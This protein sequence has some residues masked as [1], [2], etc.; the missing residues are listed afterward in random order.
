MLHCFHFRVFSKMPLAVAE[1]TLSSLQDKSKH[2]QLPMADKEVQKKMQSLL[3]SPST[4]SPSSSEIEKHTPQSAGSRFSS[5]SFNRLWRP[6]AQRN[7]RNQWLR[8]VSFKDQWLSISSSG[9]LHATS[10]VNTHLSE[11]YIPDM[12]LGALSKMLE[13]RLKACEKLSR[14]Q[15]LH[16]R[17]VLSSYRDMVMVI[18]HMVN[19]CGSMRCFSKG[20]S[21][22]P[23]VQFSS[24]PEDESDAGDGGGIAVFSFMSI[25]AFEQLAEELVK[26]FSLELCMKRLIVLELLS[27]S[28]NEA[29]NAQR[30]T[31]V[32]VDE[33]Y[34]GEFDELTT[35]NLFSEENCGPLF[36]KMNGCELDSCSIIKLNSVPDRET[37]QVYLA[38]WLVEPNINMSRVEQIFAAVSAEMHVNL[39]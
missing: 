6:A 9:R 15:D 2:L 37:L 17:K 29:A 11:R 28:C 4:P 27:L 35:C 26:M 16:R 34:Q 25:P 30:P 38:A 21:G 5:L 1:P 14:Q 22:S 18:S 13:I 12:D 3:G 23:L 19:V 36:P 8:L 32:W 39:S 24:Q 20:P 10:L 7:L 31:F 33:F